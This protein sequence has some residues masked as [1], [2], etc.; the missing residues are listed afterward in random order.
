MKKLFTLLTLLTLAITTA[1]AGE[2]TI[3]ISRNDGQF[4]NA[5]GVYYASKG[6]VTMTMSGGMNNS[7]FLVLRH[8]N[9][10]TFRSANF[11]IKKI[12]FHCLDDFLEGNN[13]VFYWGPTTMNVMTVNYKPAGSSTTTAVTPGKFTA[14]GYDGTWV[15]SFSGTWTSTFRPTSGSGTE[16]RTH[17]S[18]ENGWPAGNQLI[19]GSLGKPIRFSSIDIIVEKEDGDIYDLVTDVGQIKDQ[20]NYLIVNWENAKALSVN[21][22]VGR[23]SKDV[24]TGSPVEFI[25]GQ[26]DGI[27][28]QYAKVK[29][30]GE[31]QIIKFEKHT[32]PISTSSGIINNSRAW[33]FNAGGN[34][35]RIYS[36]AA[37]GLSGNNGP[38]LYGE[39]SIDPEWSYAAIWLG[40]GSAGYNVR[41]RFRDNSS[42]D[43]PRP[44]SATYQIGYNRTNNYFRDLEYKTED[45][46]GATAQQVRL[47][48]PA[49]PYDVTTE[50][51]PEVEEGSTPYGTIA[52]RD[53][54]IVSDDTYTS[55]TSQQYETVSFLV[56]PA[57]G[58][59]IANLVIQALST[60]G[61]D[62]TTIEP[63]S[64]T[65]TTNGTLYTFVMPANDVHIIAE[66]ADVQYHN[67]Y[68]EVKPDL[69]YGNIF[70]S[71]GYVVQDNQVKS[72]E[73]ENVVFNVM[74]NLKDIANES[75]GY[76]ELSYVTVK[77]HVTDVET[78]IAAD[79]LGNY[80]F[81]MPDNDVTI[82]AYFYDDTK[83]PLWLLGDANG[84]KW[85]YVENNETKWHTYGPRFN[86]DDQ[87]DEYYID[88]Y[89]KGTGNYGDN[90]GEAFGRFSVTWMI[91]LNDDW[92]KINGKDKRGV[93]GEPD[94]LVNETNTASTASPVYLWYGSQYEN[95]AYKIPAGIYRIK[96]GTEASQNKGN[97]NQNQLRVEK[98]PTTLTFNPA[99]GTAS[100]PAEVSKG[101][102]VALE[103]DLYNKIMAINPD[104]PAT[105]FM[106][107]AVKTI[108]DNST[109][110]TE[111]A[112]GATT[113]ITTLTEVNDGE[114]VTELHGY[115]YL[116]WIVADN[117]AYYKVINTSLKWIEENANPGDNVVVSNELV[118]VYRANSSL[119][120]KDQLPY[121]SYDYLTPFSPDYMAQFD[122]QGRSVVGYDNDN[123]IW[124]QSNWVELDFSNLENGA[125]LAASLQGKKIQA[126]TVKGVYTKPN[127]KIVLT[128]APAEGEANAYAPNTFS[129]VN[130]MA[131]NLD[132]DGAVS[133]MV[134]ED[135][136]NPHFFFLNPKVQ[137]Y[138]VV[139]NAVWVDNNTF[140]VP[141]RSAD[142]TINGHNF[143][144]AFTVD[145]SLNNWDCFNEDQ[146]QDQSAKLNEKE[147][148][149]GPQ[150]YQ[151]HAIIRK[152]ETNGSSRV[153][154][155][156][157]GKDVQ[158]D[159]TYLVY[160]LDL[161]VNTSHIVTAVQTVG[162]AKAVQSVTYCDLAG[163]M[164]S[165]PFAGVNIV[166]TRY[167]DGTVKTSKLVF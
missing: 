43:Y 107:K 54:V 166:L 140:V 154:E 158:P 137:E 83:A 159:G 124:D 6:G 79:Q 162:G 67:I 99:G 138:G 4:D 52:L 24:H 50:V 71:E 117:T 34:Y 94:F 42:T 108:G 164:S 31:A 17:T 69:R 151:F 5:Q 63:Q 27:Y 9:T 121:K 105:N 127:H 123:S 98:I 90:T 12:I 18:F 2:Q 85:T 132:E 111:N 39:S 142:Y 53:G 101:T 10:V 3:T 141:A 38:D 87:T 59:K 78:T 109:A 122:K 86:Y 148:Q 115:N 30:D 74:A 131:K 88:V 128:S 80:N 146:P 1:W 23:N 44:T 11:A 161:I 58:Y 35:L 93:P 33:T 28:D 153:M 37:S 73:G 47:Y 126:A 68:T 156:V 25:S 102:R 21:T 136:T 65:Q 56:T 157:P 60:D 49:I 145:W 113:A 130:F 91:D 61:S 96:V 16:T 114:T 72:Y 129:P 160:P 84:G 144:G 57:D 8:Q 149:E 13:D 40:A 32:L 116:G 7:N 147:V 100:Q 75:S 22:K 26:V 77:D 112:T 46:S 135:G 106:Y 29:T 55:G 41:I 110:E 97:L 163:R 19:F 64:S 143:D 66:F 82:T 15:S 119:W 95:N 20:H 89:F 118:G 152:P 51:L 167:T 134:N 125:E 14:S 150:A 70:L 139:T 92:S 45:Y 133:A 104:E 48:T 120:C 155:N 62:P 103:G 76:Y 81:T 165:K 36:S